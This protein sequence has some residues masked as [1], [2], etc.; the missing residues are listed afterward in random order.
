MNIANL[1][2]SSAKA[3]PDASATA[4]GAR[5]YRRYGEFLARATGLA[6][7]LSTAF[8]G[9]AG[10]RVAIVARNCPEYMEAM[11]AAWIAGLCVVPI[12]AKLHPRE[13]AYILG[14][15]GVQLCFASADIEDAATAAVQEAVSP[16]R[17][18]QLGGG[19]YEALCAARPI[20][21]RDMAVDAPAWLFYT[22]G[23]TGKPKGATLS[24][25]NLLGMTLRYFPDVDMLSPDDCIVHVAPFAHATGLFSLSHVAKGSRHVFL[26][27]GGFD[28]AEI[29]AVLNACTRS[30]IF[31]APTMLNRL[32]GHPACGGL[33]A[34]KVRTVIYG[35][36][37]MYWED[38]RRALSCFGPRLCQ[39]YGQGETPNTITHVSKFV[40]ADMNHPRYEA[41]LATVGI[42]R[43]GIDVQVADARGRALP[44][45]EIGEVLVRSEVTMTGYWNN[46]AAT[47]EALASGWLHTG[48][49]GCFDAEGFLTLKDR[50][51]DVIISGGSNVYP[52]EVEEVLLQHVDVVE[53]AVVGRPS[54]QWGEE[55]FAFVVLKPG[56]AV[57]DR[58]L[59]R[60]CLD[61]IARFKRP[62]GYRFVDA[63]P[64]NNYGKVLKR[65]L[66]DALVEGC[67]EPN[68]GRTS[69]AS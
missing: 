12:N 3:F 20:A 16:C 10:G 18:V 61:G 50:S 46:V 67:E 45:G 69:A 13:I 41:R 1:L 49:L 48:D 38:L 60:H 9:A 68:P 57:D 28:E 55:V 25:R 31:L 37:P 42:A 8:D 54:A 19:D 53:T 7:G 22:S 33:S 51:K 11:W 66:R 15:A 6:G 26:E 17:V 27:S 21:V 5:T 29:V 52:R 34:H 40:H 36:A 2:V 30:T 56:S 43:T 64:K 14:D 39:L 23:T 44:P 59:D 35:G 62:R 65:E 58:D 4:I 24:H 63:L 47:Q 32:I